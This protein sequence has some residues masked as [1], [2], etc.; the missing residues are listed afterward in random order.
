MWGLDFET[1]LLA[2]VFIGIFVGIV[3]AVLAKGQK[4]AK[5]FK[6]ENP[7]AATIWIMNERFIG[8]AVKKV[9]GM[10]PH[11]F[12]LGQVSKPDG[13]YLLPGNHVLSLEH[14]NANPA[15]NKTSEFKAQRYSDMNVSVEAGKDYIL[16]YGEHPGNYTLVEGKPEAT[17]L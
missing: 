7:N 9:D 4:S 13:I 3:W 14:G 11:A 6:E 10:K 17:D 5:K 15:V 12:G 2:C 8:V 1:I 16:Q